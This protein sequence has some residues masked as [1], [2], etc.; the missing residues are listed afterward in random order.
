MRITAINDEKTKV[1][2]FSVRNFNK[3]F[4]G[5]QTACVREVEGMD[6]RIRVTR[7]K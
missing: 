3:W 2:G 6:S 4:K 1:E 5:M 7:L